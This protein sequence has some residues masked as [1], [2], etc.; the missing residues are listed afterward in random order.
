MPVMV[1]VL[2][3]AAVLL[4][5]LS[6]THPVYAQQEITVRFLNYKTGKPIQKI[7]VTVVLW[8]GKV[9]G[10]N[11]VSNARL[12]TDKTGQILVHV[13]NL[14]PEHIYIGPEGV[15]ETMPG[16]NSPIS[17]AEVLKSGLV[18]H[19]LSGRKPSGLKIFAKPGEIV[20]LNKKLRDIGSSVLLI[21]T[22]QPSHQGP[23]FK[24]AHYLPPGRKRPAIFGSHGTDA[25]IVRRQNENEK[26]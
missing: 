6:L 12:K 25:R 7:S 1:R 15:S 22:G 23:K 24:V 11:R 20:D 21:P 18:V 8:N 4:S 5:L 26:A 14:I 13:P 19:S 16:W 17:V 9:P 2:A 3:L 10:E